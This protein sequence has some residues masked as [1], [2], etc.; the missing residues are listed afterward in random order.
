MDSKKVQDFI[1]QKGGTLSNVEMAE[2]LGLPLMSVAG[3]IANM[4]R[5][6]QINDHFLFT[7]RYK[8]IQK[9][10]KLAV[11]TN[12]K[13]NLVTVAKLFGASKR[14]EI[15][16]VREYIL[17]LGDRKTSYEMA[18]ELGVKPIIV[19]GGVAAL[20]REG[21]IGSKFLLADKRK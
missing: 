5:K 19:A 9:A 17:K 15:A 21:V 20:K 4:K 10:V 2:K 11:D 7:D 1:L 12:N 6:K 8:N 18:N 3:Y 13:M 16:I 14:D